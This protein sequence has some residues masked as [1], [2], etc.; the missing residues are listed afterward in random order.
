MDDEEP[1]PSSVRP[2]YGPA[3]WAGS[4]TWDGKGLP[5]AA[6]ARLERQSDVRSSLLDVPGAATLEGVGLR[7]V[8]EVMGV[9]VE[10]VGW[11]GLGCPAVGAGWS[12]VTRTLVSGSSGDWLGMG[13]YATALYRGYDV[14]LDRMVQEATALGAEGVVD[15]RIDVRGLGQ[16]NRE[17]VVLGTAVRTEGRA[18]PH[19]PFTTTLTGP[20]VAALLLGGYAPV[21]A[22]VGLAVGIRHDD[23]Q[24]Q[25]QA[26]AW[27][28]NTEVGGY[29]ELLTATKA[30][31][32]TQ[33]EKRIR[34][35]GGEGAVVDVVR[36]LV[37]TVEPVQ[38]H[39]DHVAESYLMGTAIT[40][41]GRPHPVAGQGL[42]VLPVG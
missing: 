11:Q 9:I 2:G 15:V 12:N 24:T 37:H 5:P 13:A 32:R 36:T 6:R 30:G 27:R 1:P 7:P 23:W 4:G 18:R 25:Q 21:R 3:S 20:H 31:A 29:T 14:A 38:N 34:R 39:Q 28:V 22:V 8:G 19:H 17:F 26:R 35:T 33:L 42:T 10:H 40:R 41:W 16:G